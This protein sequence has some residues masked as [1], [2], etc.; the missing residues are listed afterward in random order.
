MMVGFSLWRPIEGILS[1]NKA[2]EKF[3]KA[4]INLLLPKLIFVACHLI[5][6]GICCYKLSSLKLLPW[7]APPSQGILPEFHEYSAGNYIRS[8][9]QS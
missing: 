1:V 7:A 5:A 2:F 8:M 4:E 3:A 6:L 9:I